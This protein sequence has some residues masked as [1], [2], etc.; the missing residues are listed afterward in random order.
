MPVAQSQKE[1]YFHWMPGFY[2]FA[3]REVKSDGSRESH[4]RRHRIRGRGHHRSIR[5]CGYPEF[6]AS[7]EVSSFTVGGPTADH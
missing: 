7:T 2:N 6:V 1:I 4:I 3:V 5:Q